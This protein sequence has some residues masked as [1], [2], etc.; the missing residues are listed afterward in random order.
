MLRVMDLVNHLSWVIF[1]CMQTILMQQQ[2]PRM[3]IVTYTRSMLFLR[4]AEAL[5]RAGYPQSAMV[6]LKHGICRDNLIEYVDSVELQA[7]GT[8]VEFDPNVYLQQDVKGIHSFGSGESDCNKYYV[9]PMPA[10]SLATRQDTIDYQIPLVEDMIIDEM[11]LEFAFEGHRLHDLMRV[12][13]RRGDNAYLADPISKRDGEVD[14]AL[15]AKLMNEQ[16]WYLPL[17]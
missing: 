6:I 17:P 5:N 11:A 4:Y 10:D 9:L 3:S 16:N 2:V 14:E 7:A 1:V 8:L 15:R 13:M 12:A